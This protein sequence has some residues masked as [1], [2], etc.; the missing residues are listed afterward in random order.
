MEGATTSQTLRKGSL[1]TLTPHATEN[2]RE[3]YVVVTD[4]RRVF[5]GFPFVLLRILC[6]GLVF[7]A[8]LRALSLL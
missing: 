5:L 3:L 7:L 6:G 4:V 1:T 8:V 2:L